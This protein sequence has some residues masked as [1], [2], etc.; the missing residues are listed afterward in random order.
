M[1]GLGTLAGKRDADTFRLSE[2]P[3]EVDHLLNTVLTR[4]TAD[5]GNNADEAFKRQSPYR[6]HDRLTADAEITRD[7]VDWNHAVHSE[8]PVQK[9]LPYMLIYLNA[10]ARLFSSQHYLSRSS[11]SKT[12]V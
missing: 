8:R 3:I 7:C 5:L 2:Q 6:I 10:K 1:G 4:V 12:L 11:P 9:H